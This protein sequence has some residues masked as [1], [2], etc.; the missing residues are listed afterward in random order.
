MIYESEITTAIVLGVTPYKDTSAIVTLAGENG[1]FSVLARGIYKPKSSLKPLLISGSLLKIEYN[2]VK[3]GISFA[4]SVSIIEDASNL[5]TDYSR[6]M[7][8]MYLQEITLS[9]FAYGDSFPYDEI[10][11]ILSKLKSQGDVLSLTLLMLGVIYRRFG[12][13]MNVD[14][15]IHCHKKDHIVSYSLDAGGFICQDCLSLF[16]AKEIDNL[17]LFVLKYAFSPVSVENLN[18]VVPKTE[19]IKILTKLNEY[20]MSY[21]DI[22]QVKTI[23]LFLNSLLN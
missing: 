13:E 2:V 9:L 3:K 10:K 19:G 7:F 1:L 5:M 21:Y 8:L 15:C 23:S 20:L 12:I 6:S 14:S 18:R 22:K 16:E 17:E 11:A 4:T